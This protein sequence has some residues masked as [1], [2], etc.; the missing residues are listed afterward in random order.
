MEPATAQQ[1]GLLMCLR[2]HG[3]YWHEALEPRICP[4]DMNDFG[5][6]VVITPAG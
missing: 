1:S 3:A 6:H 4:G 2:Q 5:V